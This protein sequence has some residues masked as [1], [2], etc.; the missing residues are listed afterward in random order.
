MEVVYETGD[1]NLAKVYIGRFPSGKYVEFV[2]SIQPPYPKEKKFVLI[3]STLFGCPVGC[4]ICDAGRGYSGK[5]TAE[6]IFSQIDFLVKKN[7]RNRNINVDKFKIQFSRMGEPA[8]NNAVLDV[9]KD[10]K[11]RYSAQGFMPSISSVAPA[12]S[13]PFFE[14]LINI[15]NSIY[16]K[17]NFQLQFSIHTTSETLRDRMIPVKKWNFE[18]IAGYG[19]RFYSA[20]DRKITLNFALS[21]GSPLEAEVLKNY[22]DPEIFLIK[23]TPVNPTVNSLFNNISNAVNGK[24]AAEN[25][26]CV[27]DL[28]NEGYEVILSIGE[29][30]ENKIGSNCGQ[31]LETFLKSEKKISNDS[32]SYKLNK[33]KI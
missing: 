28:R 13:E 17:G 29:P 20:C 12:G 26:R 21:E 25:I 33:V 10:F 30:E 3:I 5:L 6:E 31:Y 2:E 18:M 11:N 16:N 7:F 4:L 24:E 27:N 23:I 15:K 8:L 32:Y 19:T 1:D 9:L 14:E 22:F